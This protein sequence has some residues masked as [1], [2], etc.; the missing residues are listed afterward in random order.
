MATQSTVDQ[1]V[2]LGHNQTNILD[3]L[4][5]RMCVYIVSIVVPRTVWDL[6]IPLFF[7]NNHV[8]WTI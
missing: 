6:M 1:Q 5:L 8:R 4:P 2:R 7:P 3:N